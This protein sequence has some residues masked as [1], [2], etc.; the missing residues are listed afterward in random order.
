MKKRVAVITGATRGIG[1][2]L[3]RRLSTH[4]YS[5]ATFYHRDEEAAKSFVQE[6]KKDCV[7]YLIKKIDIEELEKLP[8]FIDEVN[9]RFGRIDYLVNNVGYDDFSSIYD[10]TLS[11]WK[12]SQDIILN[13]P[14]VLIK[15]VLPIM[16]KQQFGRIVNIGASSNDYF[17]GVKNAAALCTPKAAAFFT[18]LK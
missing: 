18:P 3:F 14:F 11:D 16:R 4:G 17:K 2:G 9:A 13:A 10:L 6:A 12:K 15:A 5:I 1:R 8:V 7:T